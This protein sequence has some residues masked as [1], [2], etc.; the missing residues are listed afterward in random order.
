MDHVNKL[1]NC[2]ET[3]RKLVLAH[4][5][6]YLQQLLQ[7][8]DAE[9]LSST[10]RVSIHKRK[11][12]GI[13]QSTERISKISRLQKTQVHGPKIKQPQEQQQQDQ[14]RNPTRLLLQPPLPPYC[15]AQAYVSHT[16]S[17][18]KSCFQKTQA[19]GQTDRH[20]HRQIDRYTGNQAVGQ[21]GGRA[22]RYPCPRHNA[23]MSRPYSRQKH[24]Q[25]ET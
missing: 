24:R 18:Q 20:A 25:T 6:Q 2:P 4:D 23:N 10:K 11:S 16:Y 15:G 22:G 7:R 9:R 13:Q 21:V 8:L 17:A 14:D 5:L 19:Q 12:Q 3:T 1:C